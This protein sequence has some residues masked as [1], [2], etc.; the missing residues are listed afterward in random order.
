MPGNNWW[1]KAAGSG[2][3]WPAGSL[4]P[5]ALVHLKVIDGMPFHQEEFSS[6]FSQMMAVNHNCEAKREKHGH[7]HGNH[8]AP[9]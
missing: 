4:L 5:Q 9:L 7:D 6:A 3:V 2:G 8:T 1:W